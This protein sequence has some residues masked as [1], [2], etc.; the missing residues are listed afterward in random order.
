M[1]HP[2]TLELGSLIASLFLLSAQVS[3]FLPSANPAPPVSSERNTAN[4]LV[5]I[6]FPRFVVKTL[7][8]L[9]TPLLVFHPVRSKPQL[10]R[11]LRLRLVG[12]ED[13]FLLEGIFRNEVWDF[14]DEPVSRVNEAAVNE[15]LATR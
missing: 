7:Y 8:L 2:S 12:G 11:F 6:C 1:V 3:A 5:G 4:W 15:A 10:V 14:M 13:A 9:R